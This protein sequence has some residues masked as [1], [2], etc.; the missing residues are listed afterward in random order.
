V[1]R[2]E[3]PFPASHGFDLVD[4]ERAGEMAHATALFLNQVHRSKRQIGANE[5][6]GDPPLSMVPL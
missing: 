1:S 5:V 4:G 6:I 2:L 3:S